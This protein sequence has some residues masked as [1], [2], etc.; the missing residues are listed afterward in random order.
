MIEGLLV[1]VEVGLAAKRPTSVSTLKVYLCWEMEIP[2]FVLVISRPTKYLMELRSLILKEISRLCLIEEI[3]A[4]SF[5]VRI[6]S[7]TYIK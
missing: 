4:K 2:D 3:S 6:R 7:S 5:A 1:G